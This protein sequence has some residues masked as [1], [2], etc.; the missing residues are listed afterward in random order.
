MSPRMGR[1][2][3]AA[4]RGFGKGTAVRGPRGIPSVV[5]ATAVGTVQSASDGKLNLVWT[6]TDVT[7]Q[8]R[9][10]N[11]A[12]LLATANA[13]T[14]TVSLGVETYILN[15]NTAYTLTAKHYKDSIES[16]GSNFSQATTF[17]YVGDVI[18]TAQGTYDSTNAGYSW[19]GTGYDKIRTCA[20]GNNGTYTDCDAYS[21]NGLLHS[22]YVALRV[23]G[24]RNTAVTGTYT[25]PSGVTTVRI[26]ITAHGGRGTYDA[27]TLIDGNGGGAGAT[28]ARDITV[29]EGVQFPYSIG[30]NGEGSHINKTGDALKNLTCYA[31][32]P[33][34]GFGGPGSNAYRGDGHVS[35]GQTDN[36]DRVPRTA[37]YEQWGGG[38]GMNAGG[39]G[40][41]RLYP[42][43][44][45]ST[46]DYGLVGL[47][48]IVENP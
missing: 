6:N 18:S 17:R 9:I 23:R 38:S 47:L 11:G 14:T 48:A 13:G 35:A 33:A 29:S 43:G 24:D 44:N 2:G 16:A 37:I 46:N 15:A 20:N 22:D 30:A 32:D 7:A 4:A 36:S 1:T 12:T 39:S 25:V 3:G 34:D 26:F 41:S 10:Y 31:V 8:T 42:Y 19:T 5:S 40:Y 27:G 21:G 28:A 45:G